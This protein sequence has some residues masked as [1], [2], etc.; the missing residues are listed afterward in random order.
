[1]RSESGHNVENFVSTI[2]RI[3]VWISRNL[4]T[5]LGERGMIELLF[6]CSITDNNMYPERELQ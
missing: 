6:V 2:C 1:M 5:F 4:L 3:I